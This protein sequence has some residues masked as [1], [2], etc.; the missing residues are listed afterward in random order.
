MIR[1]LM[2]TTLLSIRAHKLR[3]FLTM[4]GII[5]G[6][7]SVVAIST[8][9]EGMKKQVVDATN[10]SL[11]ANELKLK[12]I[13]SDQSEEEYTFNDGTEFSFS[14]V[15]MKRVRDIEGVETIYPLYDSGMGSG[16]IDG[17][18]DYFGLQAYLNIAPNPGAN[19]VVYGRDFRSSDSGK[20][21]ILLR[22][23]IV[24]QQLG[25]T[26]TAEELVNQA[27]SIGGRMFKVIGILPAFDY[28]NATMTTDWNLAQSNFVPKDAYNELTQSK[29]ITTIV[30][31]LKEGTNRQ[32][33]IDQATTIL[34][35]AHEE[36][37]GAFGE[38]N[39]EKKNMEQIQASIGSMTMFLMA[40]T[41]ISLLVGGIGVMNIMYVSVT[42]RKREIGIRRA[43]GA[44]PRMI[45]WQ[46]LL[47]SAFITLL[48]GFLGVALGYG[49]SV[50]IGGYID[51]TPVMTVPI[52]AISTGVSTLTGL[53][54]GIIPA[55]SAARMD[56]IKA[57]YQ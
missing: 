21:V 47:E 8:L 9:G 40:I 56:P 11:S 33:V 32:Q 6:I 38:D 26:I 14:K 13:P 5:I 23:D 20:D 55:F 46:F 31:K 19:E 37:Q 10:K 48:G 57:I 30:F 53:I 45:L 36:I 50:I 28:E 22:K 25:D 52:F 42:E 24:E 16:V 4:I 54:F 41:A 51:I 34:M 39:Q 17:M 1:N 43:I 3:V 49:L 15:D 44:K 7:A 18:L 2:I 12:Y 35:E 27:V 29:P